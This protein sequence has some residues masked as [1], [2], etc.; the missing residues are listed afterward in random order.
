MALDCDFDVIIVNYNGAGVLGAA[1]SSCLAEGVPA[2]SCIVV[3]NGS[4]DA[5]QALVRDDFPGVIWIG[6]PCNAGFARAVNQGLRQ[7]RAK[8]VLILNNDAELLPGA[9][10]SLSAC[11]AA[12]PQAAVIAPRLVDAA[13]AAQNV[14]APWP[15]WWREILPKSLLKRLAPQHF[16]G[17]LAQVGEDRTVASVIGA[18]MAVRRSAVANFGPM[19]EDF[20]FYLEETEWCERAW[21]HGWQVWFCPRASVR[22]RLGAT[23]KRFEAAARI[24]F[25]RSRLL[26]ARKVEGFW[27]WAFLVLWL[28]IRTAI[29]WL[30]QGILTLASLGALAAARQRF[31]VYGHLLV[32]HLRGRP[33]HLGLPDKC[34]EPEA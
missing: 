12:H 25:H 32:W 29:D 9:L 23:A 13:G 20:F 26:Y 7:A 1:L 27:A 18:A 3:D 24:E 4:R 33:S 5:S 19:D 6:N 2:T 21:R 10:A 28:P 30:A 15:R 14:A 11:F 8:L 16:G 22:H 17:R 31:R 34:R